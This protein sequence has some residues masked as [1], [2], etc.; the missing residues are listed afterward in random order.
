MGIKSSSA[1]HSDLPLS[2]Q[3]ILFLLKQDL[4]SLN[5]EFFLL[6]GVTITIWEDDWGNADVDS[7]HG[8][9]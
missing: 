8:K 2:F 9:K 6:H 7:L 5:N 1:T 3:T 4:F